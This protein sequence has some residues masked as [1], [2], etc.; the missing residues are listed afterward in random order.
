M[1]TKTA[2]ELAIPTGRK[3]IPIP[4]DFDPYEIAAVSAVKFGVSIPT[5]LK[6][7]RGM[8]R[9]KVTNNNS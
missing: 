3:P 5:A 6:W 8:M 4:A 2:E 9:M 7:S 1:P